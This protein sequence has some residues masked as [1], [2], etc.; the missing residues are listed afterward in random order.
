[1]TSVFHPQHKDWQIPSPPVFKIRPTNAQA[2]QIRPATLQ[3]LQTYSPNPPRL[4]TQMTNT[5]SIV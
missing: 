3:R 4:P 1:M 5:L 2:Q